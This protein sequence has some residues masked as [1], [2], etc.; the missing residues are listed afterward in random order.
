MPAAIVST[1]EV[2]ASRRKKWET[3]LNAYFLPDEFAGAHYIRF[4]SKLT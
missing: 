1:S 3:N 4:F 2:I